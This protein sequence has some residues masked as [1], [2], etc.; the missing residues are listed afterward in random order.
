MPSVAE[1]KFCPNCG[2]P[3]PRAEHFEVCDGRPYYGTSPEA[4]VPDNAVPGGAITIVSYW[5]H[6]GTLIVA[7]QMHN[8]NELEYV[9]MLALALCRVA[10]RNIRENEEGA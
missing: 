2:R 10:F 8:G 4:M 9:G 3:K 1:P 6:D 7:H 5:D